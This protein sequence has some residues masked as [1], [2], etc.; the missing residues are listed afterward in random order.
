MK[1]LLVLAALALSAFSLGCQDMNKNDGNMDK[2]PKMM[3][4][5]DDCSH[6]PGNQTAKPDG[7]CPSCGMKVK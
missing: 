4:S 6:C 7:T 5:T 1:S 2:N 3:S